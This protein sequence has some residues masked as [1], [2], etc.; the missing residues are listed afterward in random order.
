MEKYNK[1]IENLLT[2]GRNIQEADFDNYLDS[3]FENKSDSEKGKIAKEI[4]KVKL[5][6]LNQIKN[7]DN[8]ISFLKR[9]YSLAMP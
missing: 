4:L 5:S 7:I 6:R 8:E 3:Y 9:S 2:I 1:E